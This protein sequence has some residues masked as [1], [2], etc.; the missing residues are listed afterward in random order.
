MGQRLTVA[1]GVAVLVSACAMQ[2]P[3]NA[4]VRNDQFKPYREIETA[5]Y[6]VGV[7][8]G[9]I[10]MR[11]GAQIDRQSG[12]VTTFVKI[13]HH[14]LGQH[15]HNYETARNSRAEALKLTVVARYGSCNVRTNCP[16]DELYGVEVPEADLRAARTTGYAFKV[17]PRVGP[18]V[19]VTVPAEMLTS[20]L[21]LLDTDRAPAVL[22]ARPPPK[23]L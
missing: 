12:A 6:R 11:L 4:V 21:G 8:P 10:T 14:Y 23:P 3:T 18:D 20:M 16:L 13:H 19:L 5:P 7:Q 9:V 22:A 15:R 17:F 1:F 2:P